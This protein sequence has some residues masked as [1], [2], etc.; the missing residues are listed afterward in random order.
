[1]PHNR[2]RRPSSPSSRSQPGDAR[3]DG[4]S[5]DGQS[6][7]GQSRDGQPRG[8]RPARDAAPASAQR[9]PG[10]ARR[11]E[12]RNEPPVP[13]QARAADDKSPFLS[14]GIALDAE[15]LLAE[16]LRFEGAADSTVS[17]FF[18]ERPAYGHRVRGLIAEAVYTALRRRSEFSHYAASGVGRFERRLL[19]LALQANG[20]STDGLNTEGE[21]T[22]FKH[23]KTI[24]RESL[25]AAIRANMPDWLWERLSLRLGEAET[26]ALAAALD[27]PAALDLR[28]NRLKSDR[29]AVIAQ[30]AK[31]GPLY[32]PKPTPYAPD[33]IRLAG[34]PDLGRLPLFEYGV[35]EVQDEGSQLLAQL[36]APRRGEMV[37]DFCAGAGGKTLA[38]GALMRGQGRLYAFDISDKRLAKLKVRVAKS[39]LQNVQVV[40]LANESD[41]RVKRLAGKIDRVLVD[42]PCSGLGTLRRNPDLKWRQTPESVAE[43]NVKQ[44]AILASASR[45]V[46]PGGRLVYATCSLLAE[47]NEVIADEF[48]ANHPDFIQ[49][50]AP[51]LLR[52]QRIELPGDDKSPYLRLWPQVHGTDGFFA[53]AFERKP[54]EKKPAAVEADAE[55]EPESDAE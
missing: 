5:R 52:A 12:M 29:D 26:L 55:A 27:V 15:N 28:V 11:A 19:L 30:L 39:G 37:V 31:A 51:E 18:R 21:N 17:R 2:L 32:A 7:D 35:I 47:E 48:L 16:V 8:D 13:A 23:L 20:V 45:M 53:A 9:N 6:R 24:P 40:T 41:L 38:L 14:P 1:M 44:R 22:W 54:A 3:R 50:D 10:Q 43:M 42:A 36:L 49:L 25:T 46:K 4:P 33:G 34:K